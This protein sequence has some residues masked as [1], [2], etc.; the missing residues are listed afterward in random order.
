[1]LVCFFAF[2]SGR[3]L[4]PLWHITKQ[5]VKNKAFLSVDSLPFARKCL[6]LQAKFSIMIDK[7]RIGNYKSI[8]DLT[9]DL[10]RFNVIIGTNGC[11]KS[12]ILEAIT[13]GALGVS[14]EID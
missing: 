12:N 14:E 1:M 5:F 11:G 6:I 4:K 13:M 9:L 7:I 3:I 8:V 2:I 10:G